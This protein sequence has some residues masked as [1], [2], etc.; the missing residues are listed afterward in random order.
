MTFRRWQITLVVGVIALLF[1]LL[2]LR[3]AEREPQDVL[4]VIVVSSLLGLVTS[5]RLE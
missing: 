5:E 1:G 4:A 3:L 2:L